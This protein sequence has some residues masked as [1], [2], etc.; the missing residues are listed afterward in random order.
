M[1]TGTELRDFRLSRA[2]SQVEFAK[3]LGIGERLCRDYENGKKTIPPYIE[4]AVAKLKEDVP[5]AADAVVR[6]RY[7]RYYRWRDK[8]TKKD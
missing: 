4:Y 3:Q 1:M 7:S 8:P 2:L 5:K 6:R